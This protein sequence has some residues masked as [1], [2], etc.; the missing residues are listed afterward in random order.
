MD[1]LGLFHRVHMVLWGITDLSI[2]ILGRKAANT[3]G[4]HLLVGSLH[5]GCCSA[6][7]KYKS[8]ICS[9]GR[10]DNVPDV[11]QS[12]L[13]LIFSFSMPTYIFFF[14]ISVF[15][16]CYLV[17]ILSLS[18]ELLTWFWLDSRGI[19]LRYMLFCVCQPE[20]YII[21]GMWQV[22]FKYSL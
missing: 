9:V 17:T 14:F 6:V 18:S 4:S 19:L 21:L 13:C 22:N 11:L 15:V 5:E 3:N 16:F 20:Q 7:T 8:Y 10:K 1:L 2:F 12:G